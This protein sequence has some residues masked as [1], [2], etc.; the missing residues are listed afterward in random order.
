V[1]IS[2]RFTELEV[3]HTMTEPTKAA[4]P[5]LGL[6]VLEFSSIGPGPHCAMLLADL[7]AEVVRIEREGGSSSE[8]KCPSARL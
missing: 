7:G 5:L 8:P 1:T 6:R 3:E 2:T 4:G